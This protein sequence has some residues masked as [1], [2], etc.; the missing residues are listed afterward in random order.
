VQLA[1]K[2]MKTPSGETLQ[3]TTEIAEYLL[4]EAKLAI[5]PFYAFGSDKSSD[6][7]R[8][9][10]GTCKEEEIHESLQMLKSALDKL[11]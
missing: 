1:L 9:S 11:S 5:V 4:K 3:N 8:L 7:F 10:V 6:W 2:G